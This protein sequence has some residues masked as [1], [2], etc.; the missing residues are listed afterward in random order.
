MTGLESPGRRP[1]A[2][3]GAFINHLI[4]GMVLGGLLCWS[5]PSAGQSAHEPGITTL[6]QSGA[7]RSIY[8]LSDVALDNL[9]QVGRGY[10]REICGAVGIADKS[11]IK[12]KAW[13][14]IQSTCGKFTIGL[15][16][17]FSDDP[18]RIFSLCVGA[19]LDGCQRAI[20]IERPCSDLRSCRA[21]LGVP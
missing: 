17:D 2:P 11:D 6:P 15:Q 12:P 7:Q 3:R 8:D 21:F 13:P 1:A 9:K 14:R 10:G 18:N 16:N 5:G 20:G 4:G 19:A